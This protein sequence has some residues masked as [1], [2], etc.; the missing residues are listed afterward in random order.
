MAETGS[1]TV[2]ATTSEAR[3]LTL[4]FRKEPLQRQRL[5]RR[6]RTQLMQRSKVHSRAGLHHSITSSARQKSV[7]QSHPKS[8]YARCRYFPEPW[9]QLSACAFMYRGRTRTRLAYSSA[10]PAVADLSP[11]HP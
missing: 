5:P 9:H 7:S 1:T 10:P 2:L 11:I 6:A 4:Q 3:Q 8:V